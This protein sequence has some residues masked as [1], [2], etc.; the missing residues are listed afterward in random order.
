MG[1]GRGAAGLEPAKRKPKPKLKPP[2]GFRAGD[3]VA[4]PAAEFFDLQCA[5][6]VATAFAGGQLEGA[7]RP[8]EFQLGSTCSR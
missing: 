8:R 2:P 6:A 5:K 4:A 1:A 7:R 3:A